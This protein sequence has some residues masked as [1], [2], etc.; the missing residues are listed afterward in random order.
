M[1]RFNIN[2]PD[3]IYDTFRE[4]AFKQNKPMSQ[5]IVDVLSA[6]RY[7]DTLTVE[8]KPKP[9]IPKGLTAT[10]AI[11]Q[12]KLCKHGKE[13]TWCTFAKCENYASWR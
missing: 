11:Q 10:E 6:T 5:V 12:P 9:F 13:K 7:F 2:L 3:H 1:K 4:I 8:G